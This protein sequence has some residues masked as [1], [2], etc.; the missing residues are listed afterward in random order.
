MGHNDSPAIVSDTAF[1]NRAF[2][3]FFALKYCNVIS[4]H[5]KKNLTNSDP[6]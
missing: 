5:M 2:P 1:I 4:M 3:F 6:G